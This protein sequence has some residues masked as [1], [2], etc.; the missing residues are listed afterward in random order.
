MGS[1]D[2]GP[3]K[4]STYESMKVISLFLTNILRIGEN[5]VQSISW[6]QNIMIISYVMII[7]N[8][9]LEHEKKFLK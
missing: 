4:K 1:V 8:E 9:F 6:P 3:V 5:P 7:I 2:N